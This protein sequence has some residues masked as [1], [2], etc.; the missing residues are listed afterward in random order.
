MLE[1]RHERRLGRPLADLAEH[2]A[3]GALHGVPAFPDDPAGRSPSGTSASPCLTNASVATTAIRRTQATSDFTSENSGPVVPPTIGAPTS[4]SA[5]MSTQVGAVEPIRPPCRRPG[6]RPSAPGPPAPASPA[7]AARPRAA[8]RRG[9]RSTA[10]PTAR[11]RRGRRSAGPRVAQRRR[12]PRCARRRPGRPRRWRGSRGDRRAVA[13]RVDDLH[14]ASR[15][16]PHRSATPVADSAA[17]SRPPGPGC[18][19]ARAVRRP[20]RTR[21]MTA[22]TTRKPAKSHVADLRVEQARDH[23]SAPVSR[24]RP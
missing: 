24:S 23:R 14:R 5:A 19:S 3:E 10:A 2:P 15:E 6:T 16:A 20:R 18:A 7:R 12:P 9:P 1:E 21:T 22:T 4:S 13:S 8:A 11:P 17:P